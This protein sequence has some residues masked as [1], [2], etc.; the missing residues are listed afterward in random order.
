MGLAANALLWALFVFVVLATTGVAI[1]VVLRYRHPLTSRNNRDEET[2]VNGQAIELEDVHRVN[3]DTGARGNPEAGPPR[4][5]TIVFQGGSSALFV[6]NAGPAF[7]GNLGAAFQGNERAT[8]GGSFSAEPGAMPRQ[9]PSDL[10]PSPPAS[11]ASLPDWRGETPGW[12]TMMDESPFG[13]TLGEPAAVH[14]NE[15]EM[16]AARNQPPETSRNATVIS[17]RHEEKATAKVTEGVQHMV[18]KQRHKLGARRPRRLELA[19]R[20]EEA[21]QRRIQYGRE[22]GQQPGRR[23]VTGLGH[24]EAQDRTSPAT[25]AMHVHPTTPTR[26]IRDTTVRNGTD[27]DGST[28]DRSAAGDTLEELIREGLR[29][30]VP[31]SLD[32]Q[33]AKN[34]NHGSLYD[35]SGSEYSGGRR[36]RSADITEEEMFQTGIEQG[37]LPSDQ[38]EPDVED[39]GKADIPE[40]RPENATESV[41][42]TTAPQPDVSSSV[43]KPNSKKLL[44]EFPHS[45][46]NENS[47]QQQ[48]T[49]ASLEAKN[50]TGK[51]SGSPS[52]DS[53]NL[54]SDEP[55]Q[56]HNSENR[57]AKVTETSQTCESPSKTRLDVLIRE[58]RVAKA[59]GIPAHGRLNGQS[60]MGAEKGFQGRSVVD[61]SDE[62]AALLR[63][64]A[65]ERQRR[66]LESERMEHDAESGMCKERGV[67]RTP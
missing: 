21:V 28:R 17:T 40:I 54:K 57:P 43:S 52:D 36:S 53:L 46:D 44:Y 1:T 34:S 9:P 62:A 29:D 35:R 38:L 64:R 31:S 13:S 65:M 10:S 8:F 42:S 14:P 50:V 55:G 56:K 11:A 58:R 7:Q 60:R 2:R 4:N 39:T 26:D 63:Q 33:T 61:E 22:M 37:G 20:E 15:R 16:D 24:Q 47:R 18:S 67:K 49:P 59:A 66:G 32:E 19:G 41:K 45:R 48:S 30:D 23:N 25:P 51:E 3:P 5:P 6:G 27:R 12:Q